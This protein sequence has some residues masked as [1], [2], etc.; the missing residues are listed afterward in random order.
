[1]RLSYHL[2]QAAAC[3]RASP[4]AAAMAALTV[5]V[6]LATAGGALLLVRALDG[7]LR[8]Y[9][10]DARLTVFLDPV[11]DAEGERLAAEVAAA[12]GPGARARFVTPD[13]ALAR[14]RADLG[15]LGAPLDALAINPLPPSVEVQLPPA[16]LGADL[17]EVREAASRLEALPFAEEVDYGRAFLDRLELLLLA[18]RA[19]GSALLALVAAVALFLVGIVV[20]L[21][22]YAR[23]DE[24]EVLRL[25]G[26][27]DGF[28][29]TPF[30][31]EGLFQGLAGGFLGAA[32]VA[33]LERWAAPRIVGAMGFGDASLPA[34]LDGPLL[35][36]FV[37]VG[38]AAGLGA[39]LLAVARFLRRVA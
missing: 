11:D 12:A 38:A 26:A 3:L 37:V 36:G 5:A 16:R 2:R 13:A 32:L 18:V 1:M 22:V 34:P 17:G 4:W 25:V 14:L 28:I 9:A 10:S 31:L 39:S 6:A 29:A 19:A 35:A 21:T 8:S 27:T 24:I 7:A 20:R 15:G 33:W 30:V 23:R